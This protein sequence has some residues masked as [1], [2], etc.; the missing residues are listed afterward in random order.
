MRCE[1]LDDLAEAIGNAFDPDEVRIARAVAIRQIDLAV[2]VGA[3]EQQPDRCV[4]D[5]AATS[6]S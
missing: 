6:A 1:R 5:L 2:R 3:F 4:D